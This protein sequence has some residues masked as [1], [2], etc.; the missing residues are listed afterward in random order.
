MRRFAEEYAKHT[1]LNLGQALQGLH[2]FTAT[3]TLI[4]KRSGVPFGMWLR[5]AEYARSA[6]SMTLQWAN[7]F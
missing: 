5:R 6:C 3:Q 4:A 1:A 2:Y 7:V